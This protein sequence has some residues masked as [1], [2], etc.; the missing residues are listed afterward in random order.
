MRRLACCISE[1]GLSRRGGIENAGN[2]R[3]PI[4]VYLKRRRPEIA[5]R[6]SVLPCQGAP[7]LLGTVPTA[8]DI[9]RL[10]WLRSGGPHLMP[11]FHCGGSRDLH[12]RTPSHSARLKQ[13]FHQTAPHRFQSHGTSSPTTGLPQ[14]DAAPSLNP[15]PR[16][17]P[18]PLAS[19]S[20]TTSA[21]R[22]AR[23]RCQRQLP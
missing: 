19:S 10:G 8:Q 5:A 12:P 18:R 9:G 11:P 1:S 2:A 7:C 17:P 16:L 14:Q 4:S 21:P 23:P 3:M 13:T 15:P 22:R 6:S 20:W